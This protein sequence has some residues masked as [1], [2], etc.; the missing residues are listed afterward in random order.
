MGSEIGKV[1]KLKLIKRMGYGRAGLPRLAEAV[2]SMPCRRP[3]RIFLNLITVRLVEVIPSHWTR[4]PTV[5]RLMPV[6]DPASGL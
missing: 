6:E 1:N 5:A 2:S 4:D 3:E